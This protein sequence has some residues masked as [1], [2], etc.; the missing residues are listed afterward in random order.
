MTDVIILN[1]KDGKIIFHIWTAFTACW[2]VEGCT[3]NH[4]SSWRSL[5][6]PGGKK[7]DAVLAQRST[8]QDQANTTAHSCFFFSYIFP[9]TVWDK[10]QEHCLNSFQIQCLIIEAKASYYQCALRFFQN[11]FMWCFN[12]SKKKAHVFMF[13]LKIVLYKIC[14]YSFCSLYRP[15]KA[16]METV[17]MQLSW[18]NLREKRKQSLVWSTGGCV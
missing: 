6:T 9:Y 7:G 11:I 10:G 1:L 14:T 2:C 12:N 13:N 16:W 18:R 17:L 3:H 15:L 4:L 8:T 5:N